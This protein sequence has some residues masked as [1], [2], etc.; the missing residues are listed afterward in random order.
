MRV[1]VGAVVFPVDLGTV[2]FFSLTTLRGAINPTNQGVIWGGQALYTRIKELCSEQCVAEEFFPSSLTMWIWCTG[3]GRHPL[4][5][6]FVIR[7]G[8][9]FLTTHY[10]S[11]LQIASPYLGP[12]HCLIRRNCYYLQ[13]G[14]LLLRLL[15]CLK[16][17]C[18]EECNM[19]DNKNCK[20]NWRNCNRDGNVHLLWKPLMMW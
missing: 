9:I 18:K 11:S 4:E 13:F 19:E 14:A 3:G 12:R 10:F 16:C 15:W 7:F 1:R 8:I 6:Q 17:F 5:K 20:I 2:F